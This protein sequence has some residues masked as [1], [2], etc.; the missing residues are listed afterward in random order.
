MLQVTLENDELR[1]RA[2]DPDKI[3]TGSDWLRNL[4]RL[5]RPVRRSITVLEEDAINR[6]IDG[7]IAITLVHPR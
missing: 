2:Y 4:Y 3:E 1:I 6:L 5:Y 7:I